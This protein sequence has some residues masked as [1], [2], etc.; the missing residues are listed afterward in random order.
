[1]SQT[2]P[3]GEE[4]P[5]GPPPLVLAVAFDLVTRYRLRLTD[6]RDG[7]LGPLSGQYLLG[8][9]A[10]TGRR[11]AFVGFY[12]PPADPDAAARDLEQ[13]LRVAEQW[14]GERLAVQGAERCDVLLVA[15]GPPP[16]IQPELAGSPA[17]SVG[18]VALDP[19]GGA[20]ALTPLPPGLPGLGELRAHLRAVR[21]GR[22]VPTLAQVDLAERQVVA[23]GYAQPT[24]R[25]MISAPLVT[26]GL[27][28]LLVGIWIVEQ[29]LRGDVI[30]REAP[31]R[32]PLFDFGALANSGAAAHDWWRYLSSAFLHDD[33]SAYHILGNGFALFFIGRLVEQLYG[34]L[35]LLGTFVLTA[36]LGSAFWVACTVVGVSSAHADIAAIGASGGVFG[37]IGMLVM[38]GRVQGRDVPVG[39]TASIRQYA[40]TIAALNL[41]FGF[42]FPHVNNYVHVGGFLAGAA[43]GL[44]LAPRR[45]VG[46][47]ALR[48]IEQA[49]LAAAVVAAVIALGIAGQHLAS[50]LSQPPSAQPGVL[51]G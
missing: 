28:A 36:G 51:N 31:G 18:A 4:L 44:L 48:R 9:A 23:G 6:D 15:L 16:R 1:M 13:R 32:S 29:T 2:A 40:I 8:A 22:P 33:R 39:V 26:Y 37:L 14:A 25:A 24:R 43:L 42:V 35:V 5:P 49:V 50:V 21:E 19:D 47:R 45:D 34:R 20:Q 12:E 10:W 46:G 7:R 3:P 38:L 41:V 11:G 30:A 17:V 27:I